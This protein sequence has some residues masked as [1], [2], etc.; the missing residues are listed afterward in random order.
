MSK[1]VTNTIETSTGGPVTLT[2]Q[3][4]TKSWINS[5]D[6]GT[7]IND[8]FNVS[9]TADTDAGRQKVALTN[10]F[11]ST[12][13]ICCT[14]AGQNTTTLNGSGNFNRHVQAV[15]GDS[16]SEIFLQSMNMSALIDVNISQYQ[17]TGDLA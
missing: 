5:V 12:T 2:K 7:S 4:A 8:S 15:R 3:N 16:T 9:S 10:A 11:S 17:A 13:T 1:I 6:N 14:T